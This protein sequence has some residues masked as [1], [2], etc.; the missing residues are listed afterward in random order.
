M[1]YPTTRPAADP[2][3]DIDRESSG[4]DSQMARQDR[5]DLPEQRSD[6]PSNAKNDPGD[7]YIDATR[8]VSESTGDLDALARD[9][10][11]DGEDDADPDAGLDLARDGL[12]P[13]E[14]GLGADDDDP[15]DETERAGDDS[16]P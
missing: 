12:A 3:D 6:Q 9:G 11:D 10:D 14:A 8:E 13:P 2:L 7:V 16:I 4:V 15:I 5:A 1:T